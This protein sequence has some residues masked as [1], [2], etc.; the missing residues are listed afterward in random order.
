M[1]APSSTE[2]WPTE[3]HVTC[4]ENHVFT[5][6][7]IKTAETK[8]G[9]PVWKGKSSLIQARKDGMWVIQDL[10]D[11]YFIFSDEAEKYGKPN[12]VPLGSWFG[13]I[14]L[15]D[16]CL[17]GTLVCIGPEFPKIPGWATELVSLRRQTN[18]LPVTRRLS[19]E[20]S[21]A[22]AMKAVLLEIQL[23]Q[24]SLQL[25]HASLDPS[26]AT[27]V[28][29][30]FPDVELRMGNDTVP[31][32][33]ELLV[34]AS[35]VFETMLSEQ[36]A[37][38]E[39]STGTVDLPTGSPKIVRS[40]LCLLYTAGEAMDSL[41]LNEQELVEMLA[42]AMEWQLAQ[43]P[44]VLIDRLLKR[45]HGCCRD[46]ALQSARLSLL[47][48]CGSGEV[49]G[50]KA[51]LRWSDLFSYCVDRIA[52]L[53]LTQD[54]F[55]SLVE[56]PLEIVRPVL[57]SNLLGCGDEGEVLVLAV[58]WARRH[59]TSKLPDMLRVVRFPFIRLTELAAEEKKV[60][61]DFAKE[62]APQELRKLLGEAA[63]IQLDAGRGVRCKAPAGSN[64]ERQQR[65]QK[66]IRCSEIPKL[67]IED[68][69]TLMCGIF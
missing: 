48:M 57:Q 17:L 49:L 31:T 30:S 29:T 26:V 33:K 62:H 40:L 43:V 24:K 32:K 53:T 46:V 38:K 2:T 60:A 21:V 39:A 45:I 11:S 4:L 35:P 5:G 44:A 41:D 28:A 69:R 47:H 59:D 22:A 67:C 55:G 61:V 14:S 27:F 6:K 18:Y 54:E 36:G 10:C 42:Q 19:F 58:K 20:T 66:R 65:M 52:K 3:L 64:S 25:L 68:F 1:A 15:H 23:Q 8:L 37:M 34:A 16:I 12:E 56:L 13:C 51:P 50:I 9:A 7:Y 63:S